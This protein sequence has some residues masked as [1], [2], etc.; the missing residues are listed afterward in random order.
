MGDC[1]QAEEAWKE[2]AV[3]KL[4]HMNQVQELTSRGH[5]SEEEINSLKEEVSKLSKEKASL[6]EEKNALYIENK[7]LKVTVSELSSKL[8]T[9][10]AHVEEAESNATVTKSR[11]E[12]LEKEIGTLSTG[13]EILEKEKSY[14]HA[15][16]GKR[17]ADLE[18]LNREQELLR[19]ELEQVSSVL[20]KAE[21]EVTCA[22]LVS[23]SY[24][25]PCVTDGLMI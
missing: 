18:K 8:G 17:A 1:P 6:M 9:L 23:S 19:E 20:S 3:L 4:E 14:L 10:S 5:L 15:V 21:E 24:N 16:A 11:L 7:D 22:K 2:I 12:V 25:Y 13:N